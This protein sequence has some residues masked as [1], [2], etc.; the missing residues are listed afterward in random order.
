MAILAENSSTR[1]LRKLFIGAIHLLCIEN[2]TD[3]LDIL[4]NG[5]FRSPIFKI[6]PVASIEVARSVIRGSISYHCWILDLSLK[7]HN[8]GLDLLKLK[9]QFPWCVVLSGAHSMDDATEAIRA[10]CYGV[11][12]KSSMFLRNFNKFIVEVCSLSTLSFILKAK[13]PSRF[14]MFRILLTENILTPK[15]WSDSYCLNEYDV[16]KT[17][18]ENSGLTAKQFLCFY[19]ALRSILLSDCLLTIVDKSNTVYAEINQDLDFKINCLEFVLSHIDS[20]YARIYLKK[21]SLTTN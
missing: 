13:R 16:R 6:N 12:D 11:F 4:C 8:D 14:D 19:H 1:D 9:P 17:C 5:I 18:V 2:H 20:L 21:H 7:Q 3:I 10:G 15:D